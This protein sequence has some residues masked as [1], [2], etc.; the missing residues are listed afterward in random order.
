MAERGGGGQGGVGKGGEEGGRHGGDDVRLRDRLSV[1][2]G[3]WFVRVRLRDPLRRDKFVARHGGH[4]LQH[5]F[6]GDAAFADLRFHHQQ[7]FFGEFVGGAIARG[8][9][10]HQNLLNPGNRQLQQ[11]EPFRKL[12]SD[13]VCVFPSAPPPARKVS[14]VP[15]NSG[16]QSR[17]QERNASLD[18]L[19]G[20][21]SGHF[22]KP[23]Q[24]R[25]GSY[26]GCSGTDSDLHRH[27]S[28]SYPGWLFCGGP[29][30]SASFFR[31]TKR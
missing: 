13:T 12:Y 31:R 28:C 23:G 21:G 8:K 9:R 22:G 27:I 20:N 15:S 29:S 4:H 26:E 17:R 1:T 6:G 16:L 25:G 5:A 3:K 19:Y 24:R 14:D 18:F 7:A 30:R 10:G 2:D 11:E